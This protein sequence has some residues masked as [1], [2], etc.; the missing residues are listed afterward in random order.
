MENIVVE[1]MINYNEYLEKL[2]VGSKNIYTELRN[3]EVNKAVTQIVDFSEGVNWMISVNEKL[4]NLGHVNE[5][6]ID[7]II[8]FLNEI[9]NG[10]EVKDYLLVADIFEHEV[11]P[12]FESCS[13]Y[14]IQ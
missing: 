8:E 13:T 7:Q 6:N 12:F 2:V 4:G 5:L 3:S 14:N 1:T 11:V 9:N 10:L